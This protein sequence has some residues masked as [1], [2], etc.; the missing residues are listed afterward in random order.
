MDNM[1][2]K[3]R[4]EYLNSILNEPDSSDPENGAEEE[5]REISL[6]KQPED[7]PS[8]EPSNTS[9]DADESE[10]DDS[11][12]SEN[13]EGYDENDDED[14]E[15]E[16]ERP[17]RRRKK[18]KKHSAGRLVFALVLA[19][20]LIC[21]SVF[22]AVSIMNVVKS[23]T[24]LDRKNIP[25]VIEIPDNTS[26]SQIADILEENGIIDN[27]DLF[28][29]M[30]KFRGLDSS[31]SAGEHVLSPNMSYS[32]IMEEL[33]KHYEEEREVVDITFPE[34]ITIC[35]AADILEE[36][37]V[38]SKERFIYIF[39]S[40]SFGFDFE[41]QVATSSDKF[42]KMEGF[43]F[44]DTYSFYVDEEAEVVAKKIYKNFENKLT[45]DYYGRMKDMGLSLEET[46]TLASM[47]QAEGRTTYDMKM[48]SAVFRNRLNNK[49][50]P[51]LESDPTR[52]YVEETIKPNIELPNAEMYKKYNT[53]EGEGLPPGAI[54]NPGLDAIS[55]VLYPA[56]TD[57][58][59]FCA[60]LETGEVFYAETLE[61]HEENLVKAHLKAAPVQSTEAAET[62]AGE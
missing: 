3:E 40:S 6:D 30:A 46:I 56:D 49:D 51:K 1:S 8:A 34:G 25:M 33:C 20:L 27:A 28:A 12:E 42:M 41:K 17:V 44:P 58:L 23:I 57:A 16:E 35:E 36:K 54:C 2:D 5:T 10:D 26:A 24:G 4:E 11:T 59:F 53:Y 45:P 48:I 47:I 7:I 18:K 55:A 29:F 9:E 61:E 39:N 14:D 38:C 13:N 15:E 31:F 32:D 37:G 52:K 62:T 21:L 50:F 22:I 43:L 60:D 19:T